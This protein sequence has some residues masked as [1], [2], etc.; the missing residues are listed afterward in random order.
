MSILNN[1]K[2]ELYR[3]KFK[4]PSNVE[5]DP[6]PIKIETNPIVDPTVEE[7]KKIKHDWAPPKVYSSIEEFE[8]DKNNLIENLS[9]GDPN[10]RYGSKKALHN[11]R[12]LIR[13]IGNLYRDYELAL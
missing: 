11:Y 10:I 1:L 6:N 9:A 7:Q 3:E 12:E 5:L 13:N 2:D 4:I 8:N